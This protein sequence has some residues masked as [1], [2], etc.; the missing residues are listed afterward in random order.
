[1]YEIQQKRTP[2]I[3]FGPAGVLSSKVPLCVTGWELKTPCS[4][5]EVGLRS[6]MI[7]ISPVTD[8]LAPPS[9][10]AVGLFARYFRSC[11]VFIISS[12]MVM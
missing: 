6:L 7:L 10:R 4:E 9:I 5:V 1:M 3:S 2:R 12:D 11:S 8:T